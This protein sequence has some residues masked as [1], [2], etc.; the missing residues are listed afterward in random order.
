MRYRY[1]IEKMQ[2]TFSQWRGK[3]PKKEHTKYTHVKVLCIVCGALYPGGCLAILAKPEGDLSFGILHAVKVAVITRQ[4][5]IG[6]GTSLILIVAL[7][8]YIKVVGRSR[9]NEDE[10]NFSYSAKGTY[11][12]SRIATEEEYKNYLSITDSALETD[13]IILGTTMDGKV[14]SIPRDSPYN[15]NMFV[16]GSQG[17]FKSIAISRNM[18]IQCVIRGES[19]CVTDPKGEL[20]GDMVYYLYSQG[21]EVGLWNLS[22]R[23][24]SD[25]WDKVVGRSRDNEDERNFS[26]SAKGTYGTSRIATEEEYKNY[27]SITDSALETDGII[28][29]TT[30]D[31]KVVSI[32]RDSPY[33]RNMF[34]AGSQGS[35][36]SIA[37]SRNMI[38]QCVIRG[39]SF[40][41]TDPKGELCG[42][43]VYYLYSQGYEVGLWNLSNRWNSDGWDIL[44][45]I[46]GEEELEYVDIICH[47]II[48]NTTS[49]NSEA[50][51]NDIEEVLLKALVLYVVTVMPKE[52][53]QFST[54]YNMLLQ[55]SAAS[56]D[57]K[58]FALPVTH[59][60]RQ[61]YN[62]FCQSP[63]N[64]GN[65]ILGL[66]SRLKIFQDE[67]IKR[68]TG[69]QQINLERMAQKKT[70]IFCM[71]SDTTTTYNMLNAL[72]ISMA[73][74]KIMAYA[75]RQP[76]RKCDVPVYF[77][78]DEMP[79]IGIID[80]IQQKEA[81]ARSR[82]I[83]M[84]L[85]VQN[86]PQFQNRYPDG[87]WE[88]LVGGCDFRLFL[89]CNESTTAEYFSALT[90]L[91]TIEVETIRK[92]L[93]TV[94]LTDY[95]PDMARNSG[96]GQRPV[97]TPDEIMRLD[98]D[99]M[100]LFVRGTKMIR[101]KKFPFYKHPEALK[102]R[103]IMPQAF[104]P[105]W[106]YEQG[107]DISGR[108]CAYKSRGELLREAVSDPERYVVK[109]SERWGN[110]RT[111]LLEQRKKME[112]KY[113][114][115]GRFPNGQAVFEEEW[116][117]KFVDLEEDLVQAAE[118]KEAQKPFVED[119][120]LEVEV[121]SGESDNGQQDSDTNLDAFFEK[122]FQ[123][124]NNV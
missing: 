31:G 68:M 80:S 73:F 89:G 2:Q 34:V 109:D 104:L 36:K 42:D 121:M 110:Q 40:C 116:K 39:E 54:A 76:A 91:S 88:E 95:V 64:K 63:Q 101:L 26:Y 17:S 70:A 77:I 50:F 120:N 32:P 102:L 105:V 100:F 6:Y 7:I 85:M 51:F 37:I 123:N 41:V 60:A 83:G 45:E 115:E 67:A 15:R 4:G 81:T 49:I 43:M 124:Q 72:M 111:M 69:Y 27:L 75:D 19:F 1:Y 16:A 90:G 30:M 62:L 113:A 12:T 25:G 66:G 3:I 87:V 38:I 84:V 56:L 13:G 61:S 5:H 47:T 82:D 23:W 20:C 11:G 53:H 58:F 78:L 29:G 96:V 44:Q 112:E 114:T 99:E 94:R 59:P 33:N 117:P 97:Y 86:I 55:E 122:L 119:K 107:H 9:D 93:K 92:N 71:A 98:T 46:S 22:N 118:E 65:A 103:R 35:F 24:N 21:Y 79:N 108:G 74:I 10:R 28:L 18:I 48:Q 57:A 14:V 8:L 52:L 106:R